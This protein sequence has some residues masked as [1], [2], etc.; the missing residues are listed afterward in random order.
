MPKPKDSK[1]SP[2]EIN[3]LRSWLVSRGVSPSQAAQ[4]AVSTVTRAEISSRVRFWLK[5]RPKKK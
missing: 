4:L 1:P 5:D 3:T 2:S